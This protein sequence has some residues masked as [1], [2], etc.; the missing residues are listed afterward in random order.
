M[1]TNKLLITIASAFILGG[2]AT[3]SHI[4]TPP[5][6]IGV[7]CTHLAD[8]PFSPI[9]LGSRDK[10]TFNKSAKVYHFDEGIGTFKAYTLPPGA[11]RNL[12]METD[13]SSG[14]IPSATILRPKVLFL[15]ADKQPQQTALNPQWNSQLMPLRGTYWSSQVPIPNTAHYAIIYNAPKTGQYSIAFSANG[16]IHKVPVAYTG[17]LSVEIK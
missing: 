3:A 6:D 8:L 15:D 17:S 5:K 10:V 16:K 7:C 14:Y 11:D 12:E 13:L 1:S 4:Q 2:C 9:A